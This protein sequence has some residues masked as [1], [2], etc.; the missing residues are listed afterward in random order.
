[1]FVVDRLGAAFCPIIFP[2]DKLPKFSIIDPEFL[3][4]KSELKFKVTKF[5]FG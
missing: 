5:I 1:M 4:N 2:G 3:N